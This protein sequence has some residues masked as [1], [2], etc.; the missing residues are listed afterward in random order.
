MIKTKILVSALAVLFVTYLLYINRINPKKKIETES[1]PNFQ[2]KLLKNPNEIILK[3]VDV[4]FDYA[5]GSNSIPLAVAALVT[6]GDLLEL[7][8]GKFSTTLLHKIAVD[9]QKQLLSVDSDI[10][11]VSKFKFYNNTKY[12]KIFSVNN[13]TNIEHKFGLSKKKMWGVVLVDH[14]NAVQRA[15]DAKFYAQ[16]AE[17][18][19]VHDAEKQGE[20][21]YKY[22]VNGLRSPFKYYCKLT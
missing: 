13:F 8:M 18:V 21:G 3:Y 22:E 16:R 1:R 6:N 15:F 11:W 7:G 20:S 5:Y 9:S 4:P 12:H 17:I 2:S 10:N 14:I 19:I